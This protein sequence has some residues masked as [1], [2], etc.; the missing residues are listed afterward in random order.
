MPLLHFG[1]IQQLH[2]QILKE[3]RLLILLQGLKADQVTVNLTDLRGYAVS[4]KSRSEMSYVSFSVFFN[5]FFLLVDLLPYL[6]VF[7]HEG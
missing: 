1:D 3:Q 6:C 2:I 7:V 4:I 5:F